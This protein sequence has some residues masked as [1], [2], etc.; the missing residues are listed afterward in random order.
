MKNKIKINRR[1]RV[2][3]FEEPGN[4]DTHHR[5][6]FLAYKA[7]TEFQQ[8]FILIA[9]WCNRDKPTT[10]RLVNVDQLV[11]TQCRIIDDLRKYNIN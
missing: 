4:W 11:R 7:G 3:F 2:H 1:Q 5:A 6:I 9:D 10:K 8:C